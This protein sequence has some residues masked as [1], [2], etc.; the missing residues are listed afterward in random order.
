MICQ[1]TLVRQQLQTL[2]SKNYGYKLARIDNF[3][4]SNS[5]IENHGVMHNGR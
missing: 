4:K 1:S 5:E 2:S 3:E